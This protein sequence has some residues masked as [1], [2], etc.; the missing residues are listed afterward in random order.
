MNFASDGIEIIH[1]VL[2][3]G[4][5]DDLVAAL[6]ESVAGLRNLLQRSESVRALAHSPAIRNLLASLGSE[7]ARPVRAVFFDKNPTHNWKVPW[8]QDL[9]IAVTAR[10]D[11]PGFKN[12][13]IKEGAP[14]VQPPTDF[15]ERM[16]TIRIHLDDCG[17]QNG[18][19]RVVPGSHLHGRLD[20]MEI[21][22]LT[23]TA[24]VTC[25]VP[26][27]G[28]IVMRPLLLHASSPAVLPSHRRVVHLE[29]SPDELPGG[30]SWFEDDPSPATR[31]DYFPTL[32]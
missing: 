6:P 3:P 20:A 17:A 2:S 9:T 28:A 19:L 4:A 11:V 27:G 5:V 18:P 12:W 14:H 15:L 32:L 26:S 16:I 24:V 8:H 13:S 10:R 7:R 25:C 21:N 23:G 29:F 31:A 1:D 30:L 22:R